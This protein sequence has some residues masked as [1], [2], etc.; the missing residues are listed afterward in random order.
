MSL[1]DSAGNERFDVVYLVL[2]GTSTASRCPELLRGLI[3]L[4]FSTVIAIPT[5]NASRV[6]AP[7]DLADVEGVQVVESI[8]RSCHPSTT[9][10]W[11]GAVCAVQLQFAQQAGARHCR[12]PRAVRGGRGDRARHAGDRGSVTEPAATGPSSRSGVAPDAPHLAG[13]DRA[14]GGRGR[15]AATGP[16][17]SVVRCRSAICPSGVVAFT[18]RGTAGRALDRAK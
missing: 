15:G 5:P 16:F 1:G 13:Y 10:A 18:C 14:A 3:G 2:S 12:Q 6:I 7:R 9:A 4:G 8:L 11:C 17:C